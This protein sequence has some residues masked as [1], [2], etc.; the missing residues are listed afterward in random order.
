MQQQLLALLPSAKGT[1]EEFAAQEYLQ[2]VIPP[3]PVADF[4]I[5]VLLQGCM[6]ASMHAAFR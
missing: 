6:K 1:A 3:A 2:Q 5:A 4:V